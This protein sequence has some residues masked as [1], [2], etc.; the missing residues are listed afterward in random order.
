MHEQV[1]KEG[2]AGRQED[3][4]GESAKGAN[5][6]ALWGTGHSEASP[7]S[8]SLGN[9]TCVVQVETPSWNSIQPVASWPEPAP[10]RIPTT[11]STGSLS[12]EQAT[13]WDPS[14]LGEEAHSHLALQQHFPL[15]TPTYLRSGKTWTSWLLRC[16]R[17]GEPMPEPRVKE[18]TENDLRDNTFCSV[19]VMKY[20]QKQWQGIG[21]FPK[22]AQGK[23][24]VT[25]R[26]KTRQPG[27]MVGSG[28][29]CSGDETLKV[30]RNKGFSRINSALLGPREQKGAWAAWADNKRAQ[31]GGSNRR[32]LLLPVW[33]WEVRDQSA[34][35]LGSVEAP[36]WLEDGLLARCVLSVILLSFFL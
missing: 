3:R 19:S 31:A 6:V 8:D 12:R 36:C 11:H 4:G 16:G 18:E 25:F 28:G 1:W 21:A 22:G 34:R 14:L 17:E 35:W 26:Q 10:F 23:K 13:I 15:P 30:G 24:E 32:G 9:G 7:W 27:K 33:R 29:T 5:S 20:E 2:V